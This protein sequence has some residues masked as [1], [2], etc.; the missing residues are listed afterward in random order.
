MLLVGFYELFGYLGS[1]VFQ[2]SNIPLW[3]RSVETT[4]NI[5]QSTATGLAFIV[6]GLFAYYRFF[7]EETHSER[8]QPT[9]S[10]AVSRKDDKIFIRST[11]E[12]TNNGLTSIWIDMGLTRVGVSTRK[13]GIYGWNPYIVEEVFT[14]SD[15]V[16]PGET[17]GD[18]VWME[19]PD[20][21]YVAL[22]IE[23]RIA[24]VQEEEE[25]KEERILGWIAR[26]IV[27]LIQEPGNNKDT[28]AAT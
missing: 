14:G 21:D 28:S 2:E 17:V 6:G 27:D 24:K 23:L 12:M 16:R 22:Q 18:Q 4:A 13:A 25:R 15:H 19:I 10:A 26:D 1:G 8:L 3:L 5:F 7:K 9:V 11:A 20:D